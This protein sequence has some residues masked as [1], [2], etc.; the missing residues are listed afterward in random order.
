MSTSMSTSLSSQE[1]ELPDVSLL[2]MGYGFDCL[3]A[4]FT[5][6]ALDSD[7]IPDL[8]A[9]LAPGGKE[10]SFYASIIESADQLQKALSISAQADFG[11]GAFGGS[12]SAS[13]ATFSQ[14]NS[15]DLFIAGN[16]DVTLATT[17]YSSSQ[18]GRLRLAQDVL[19]DIAAWDPK[20]QIANFRNNWGDGYISAVRTGG[21]L[22]FIVQISCYSASDKSHLAAQLK[23]HGMSWSFQGDFR[24]AIE[25]AHQGRRV[26]ASI[27][28]AGGTW[29]FTQDINADSLFQHLTDFPNTVEASSWAKGVEVTLYR[30]VHNWP[31]SITNSL[32]LPKFQNYISVY[33]QWHDAYNELLEDIDYIEEN[34]IAFKSPDQSRLDALRDEIGN[35]DGALIDHLTEVVTEPFANVDP[36]PAK[37]STDP[38]RLRKKLPEWRDDLPRSA[39]DILNL[40]PGNPPKTGEYDIWLNGDHDKRVSLWCVFDGG[41][42]KEYLMLLSPNSSMRRADPSVWKGTDVVVRWKRI[43]LDP[44]S[45]EVTLTDL[46]GAEVTGGCSG[47]V[48]VND[49]TFGPPPNKAGMPYAIAGACGDSGGSD[50]PATARVDLTDTLFSFHPSVTFGRIGD[51]W[52][53]KGGIKQMTEQVAEFWCACGCCTWGPLVSG[54]PRLVLKYYS[55]APTADVT[56]NSP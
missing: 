18:T 52:N 22:N 37:V 36:D 29:D 44:E 40:S 4:Q 25:T 39:Q 15:Y 14:A 10:V 20:D 33:R 27:M 24:R 13:Y 26:T 5:T 34:R 50:Y 35:N 31:K 30:S 12:F 28:Q 1:Y 3:Q 7:T 11:F 8:T 21:T 42:A 2:N 19:D 45:L 38:A 6:T 51:A 16:C 9:Q 48:A 53:P 54:V 43:R 41:E 32:N 23:G 56:G 46:Y 55:P 49:V 47:I 17:R